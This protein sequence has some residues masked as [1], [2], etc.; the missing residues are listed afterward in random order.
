MIYTH[1]KTRLLLTIITGYRH[2]A[3]MDSV[4]D[5]SKI[6]IIEDHYF[7]DNSNLPP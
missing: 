3:I 6:D 1:C 5:Y 2:I 7:L 4:I